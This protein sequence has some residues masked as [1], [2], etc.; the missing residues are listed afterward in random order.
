MEAAAEQ[1]RIAMTIHGEE[2]DALPDLFEATIASEQFAIAQRLADRMLLG[3]A[4]SRGRGRY[5]SAIAAVFEGRFA[6]A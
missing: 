5:R 1:A 2:P 3:S 6:A 4:L